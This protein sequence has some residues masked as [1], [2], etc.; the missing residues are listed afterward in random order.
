[1]RPA[2]RKEEA[3]R[4]LRERVGSPSLPSLPH[5]AETL[6][7]SRAGYGLSCSRRCRLFC[8]LRLG[9]LWTPY[10][11]PHHRD[12]LGNDERAVELIGIDLIRGQQQIHQVVAGFCAIQDFIRG[13]TA[14]ARQAANHQVVNGDVM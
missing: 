9:K 10:G 11:H 14:V 4:Q 2:Y 7:V 8:K 12:G 5:P 6:R 3:S 13:L 1:M